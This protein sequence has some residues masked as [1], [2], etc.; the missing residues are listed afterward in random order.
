[1]PGAFNL[2]LP[3][4]PAGIEAFYPQC[5][6]KS[7]AEDSLLWERRWCY[8]RRSPMITSQWD[9][10][11]I[12]AG[13][14]WPMIRSGAMSGED[15]LLKPFEFSNWEYG[16]GGSKSSKYIMGLV[17]DSLGNPLGG[18]IIKGF[19]TSDDVEVGIET[20]AN[21]TGYFEVMCPYSPNDNH[22]LLG[23]YPTG[24]LAGS[25]INTLVP[26][27]RDGTV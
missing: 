2:G 10:S 24:P 17:R 4:G 25:T 18:A 23:Y 3:G 9:D 7:C 6:P 15:T 19:R 1:M 5:F 11:F 14:Y 21:D 16:L 26:T 12:S 20:T 27:W 8:Q 13:A 22:Y